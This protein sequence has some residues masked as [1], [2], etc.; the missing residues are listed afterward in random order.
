MYTAKKEPKTPSLLTDYEDNKMKKDNLATLQLNDNNQ[1]LI[2]LQT[3]ISK[4]LNFKS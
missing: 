4:V 3:N 1:L 2:N